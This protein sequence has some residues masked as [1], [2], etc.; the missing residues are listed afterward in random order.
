MSHELYFICPHCGNR[1]KG[2]QRGAGLADGARGCERCGSAYLFELLDDYYP[3]P[4]AAFFT[5]DSA[6]RIVDCGR[7]AFELAGLKTE[8]VIGQPLGDTLQLDF[9]DGIDHVATALEW[10]VRV[11]GK[12]AM[13]LAGS[14]RLSA[15]ADIFPAYDDVEDR[16]LLVVLTPQ[17][18]EAA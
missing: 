4:S 1:S 3:A 10:Q 6:S 12:P 15:I 14:Q 5:C 2:T 13:I 18:G 9:V 16:G 7:G 8:N 17:V 11:I